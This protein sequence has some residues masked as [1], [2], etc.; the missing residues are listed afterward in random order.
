[1][2]LIAKIILY[3]YT[4]VLLV[5]SVMPMDQAAGTDKANHFFAYFILAVIATVAFR[6]YARFYLISFAYAVIVGIFLEGVQ[7]FIPYRSFDLRDILANVTGA[8]I[9][10]ALAGL[11]K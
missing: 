9:G 5:L 11:R 10:V 4:F 6:K 8:G 3:G 1:M 7:F 2:S